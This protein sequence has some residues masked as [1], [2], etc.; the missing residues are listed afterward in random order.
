MHVETK[1]HIF[2]SKMNGKPTSIREIPSEVR[3]SA[4]SVP[5]LALSCTA[6]CNSREAPRPSRRRK[7]TVPS[8]Y[9]TC[10]SLGDSLTASRS[11]SRASA[12]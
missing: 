3:I 12:K 4:E 8:S 11:A 6:A 1:R 9:R 7:S 2:N 5:C 10:G